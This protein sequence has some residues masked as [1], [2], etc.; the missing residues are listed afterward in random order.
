MRDYRIIPDI[1]L[2]N[3]EGKCN[4]PKCPNPTIYW[5][6]AVLNA[7][8]GKKLPLNEPFTGLRPPQIHGCMKKHRPG[9]FLDKYGNQAKRNEDYDPIISNINYSK[10]MWMWPK[11]AIAHYNRW[12]ELKGRC[13]IEGCECHWVDSL[14]DPKLKA[15]A[16]RKRQEWL[17]KWDSQ[18]LSFDKFK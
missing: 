11:W 14:K 2:N 8:T 4:N 13:D 5:N 15:L 1:P 16:D 17:D 12:I 7:D 10:E 18:P 3:G 6:N 9:L